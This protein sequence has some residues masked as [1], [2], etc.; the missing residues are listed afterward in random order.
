MIINNHIINHEIKLIEMG[1]REEIM[2]KKEIIV[3][4]VLELLLA[5]ITTSMTCPSLEWN[6]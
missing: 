5:S 2:L 3:S 1:G 6:R 4:I